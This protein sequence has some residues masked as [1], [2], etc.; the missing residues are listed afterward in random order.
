VLWQTS[1]D[2]SETALFYLHDIKGSR[3]EEVAVTVLF[4][5]HT[6]A[7]CTN[8]EKMAFM[9]STTKP[10]GGR[11]KQFGTGMVQTLPE[12]GWT[13]AETFKFQ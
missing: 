13:W 4:Q 10:M 5:F 9:S 6:R 2:V 11:P 3:D 12:C 8:T 1:T 7:L